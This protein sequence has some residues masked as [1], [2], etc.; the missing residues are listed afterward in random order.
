MATSTG[1]TVVLQGRSGATYQ[2]WVYPWGESFKS[3]AGLYAVLRD[4]GT[5]WVVLY[6]GQTGDLSVRFDNHHRLGDFHRYRKTHIA[7]RIEESEQ[8]RLM[9]E[10]DLCA[11]YTPPCNG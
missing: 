5:S 11:F 7:A 9:I 1:S 2:F 10:A 8:R 3:A 6:V 4:D